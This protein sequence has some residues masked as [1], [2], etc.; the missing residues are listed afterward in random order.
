MF[1]FLKIKV[2][3]LDGGVSGKKK[4]IKT[5]VKSK[6]SEKTIQADQP[7]HENAFADAIKISGMSE[8]DFKAELKGL[9]IAQLKELKEY[10]LHDK[11]TAEKK[12][13][14]IAEFLPMFANMNIV[15][16]KF[17]TAIDNLKQMVLDSL[18]NQCADE[19]GDI[20][21]SRVKEAV[22]IRIGI[23]E[24]NQMTE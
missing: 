21:M 13:S 17:N 3:S 14:K 7:I 4:V 5:I 11:T 15:V 24:E 6:T 2:L 1:V 19:D 22:E 9:S 18:S 12:A 10:I 20:K 8:I 23:K 16:M